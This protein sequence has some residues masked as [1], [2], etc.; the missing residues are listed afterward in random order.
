MSDVTVWLDKD[1]R[2]PEIVV[3]VGEMAYG[4]KVP[5]PSELLERHRKAEAEFN[6]VQNILFEIFEAAG[7]A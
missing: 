7:N 3:S 1:E 2:W 5:I 6:E 4:R